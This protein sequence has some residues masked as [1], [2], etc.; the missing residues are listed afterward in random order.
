MTQPGIKPRFPWSLANTLTILHMS[1]V[2]IY[3]FA[4]GPRDLGSI[5]GRIIPK[6]Q[7][8]VFDASLLNT[9]HYN[10][11]IKDK[12]EQSREMNYALPFPTPWCSSYRK[13]CLQVTL[14]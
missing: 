4:N 5:P 7:K 12:V 8:M 1:D 10:V 14:D 6:N 3:M 9:Q 2:Y 11:W 13:G